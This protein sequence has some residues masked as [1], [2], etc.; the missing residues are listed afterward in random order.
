MKLFVKLLF[1]WLFIIQFSLV[2]CSSQGSKD[3]LPDI[4]PENF[5]FVFNYGVNAKNGL[6]TIKGEY[7]KDMVIDPAVTTKLVLS[8]EEMNSIYLNMKKINILNYP[9]TFNPKSNTMQTPFQTYSLK[10]VL[11]G[12]EKNISWKDENVSKSKEAVQLRNLFLKIQEII[13]N[14]EEYNK[15]PPA[16]GGYD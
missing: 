3:V 11:D 8:N 15:L 12:S 10:I 1:L 14:K 7:T 6:N 4:K 16:N 5:N 9:E 13:I 2:G